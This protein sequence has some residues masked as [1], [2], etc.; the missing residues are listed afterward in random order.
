M[1]IILHWTPCSP[2]S[3]HSSFSHL[4]SAGLL[5]EREPLWRTA[6]AQVLLP[7]ASVWAQSMGGSVREPRRRSREGTGNFLLGPCSL[8]WQGPS[9]SITEP[10]QMALPPLPQRHCSLPLSPWLR[11]VN[12]FPSSC[13][14][15]SASASHFLFP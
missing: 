6:S 8:V 11:K 14:S 12:A 3:S 1:W 9:P 13:W 5:Q 15:L 2:L 4:F 7:P 10:R